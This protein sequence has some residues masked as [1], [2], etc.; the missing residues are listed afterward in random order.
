MKEKITI[1]LKSE[2]FKY[3]FFGGLT[4][5]V[6][7]VF[8]ALFY[9]LLGLGLNF[10]NL[11]GII[12]SI[13]FAFV[14]NKLFVFESR[15]TNIKIFFSEFLKFISGRAFTMVLELVGVWL[16][17]DVVLLNEY[18]SKALLQILVI[19]GNYFISKFIVFKNNS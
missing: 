14:T 15:K 9:N 4:T 17:V 12:I 3:L 1:F 11:S 13:I 6:N 2:A 18:I 19:I 5:A 10:S 8:F 16:L 7:F